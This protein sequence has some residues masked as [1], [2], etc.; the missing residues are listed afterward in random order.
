MDGLLQGRLQ[1]PL[2]GTPL[3]KLDC[4]GC[5]TEFIQRD[6]IYHFVPK[7]KTGTDALGDRIAEAADEDGDELREEY[8]SYVLDEERAARETAGKQFQQRLAGLDGVVLEIASGM[9]GAFPLLRR[10]ES[11]SP[12]AS[13]ISVDALRELKKSV[14]RDSQQHAFLACDARQLPFRD[15]SLD[16]VVSVGG[17][18]NVSDTENAVGEVARVLPDGGQLVGVNL[19]VDSGSESADVA[20]EHD[21]E[22]AYLRDRFEAVASEVFTEVSIEPVAEATVGENPYDILPIAGDTQTYA[23]VMCQL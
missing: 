18:N 11:I 13:D 9:G 5:G 4:R 10:D 22:T 23:T 12:I 15:G 17:F 14:E 6:G 7:E 20:V 2:C 21:L 8:E 16:G 1:C 19:F 3:R